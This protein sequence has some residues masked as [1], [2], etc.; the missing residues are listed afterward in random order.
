MGKNSYL[1]GSTTVKVFSK[2]SKS[3][4]NKTRLSANTKH[5]SR[6]QIENLFKEISLARKENRIDDIY[7]HAILICEHLSAGQKRNNKD[8]KYIN[9]V[10]TELKNIGV[11]LKILKEKIKEN[12]HSNKTKETT[13]NNQLRDFTTPTFD[14]FHMLFLSQNSEDRIK[15]FF[16][17]YTNISEESIVKGMHL[18]VYHG[19]REL[20]IDEEK[21]Y[22]SIE[23][24]ILESRFMVLAPG[25]ENPSK[26]FKPNDCSVGIRLTKRNIAIP[27]IL[28]IRRQIY[29]NEPIFK[30]RKNTTDWINAFGSRNYQPHIKLLRPGSNVNDNLTL[31]GDELRKSIKKI[32]FTK[33]LYRENHYDVFK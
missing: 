27:N 5:I 9:L 19:R 24:D 26:K 20:P 15:N 33:L 7:K 10:F 28:K 18:T 29:K 30:K 25:G 31:I 1:G 6:P 17:K 3:T 13:K 14:C 21:T 11:N 2:Y 23:A 4:I 8:R 12:L 32:E 22:L 16:F